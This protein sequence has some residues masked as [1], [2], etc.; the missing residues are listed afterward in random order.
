[1][2]RFSDQFP[3][4]LPAFQ[5]MF[6]DDATCARYLESIRWRDGFQCPRCAV[7]AEPIRVSRPGVLRCRGCKRDIALTA[8]T[9]MERTHT[10]LSAWF[11]AA[12]LVSSLTPGM[13]AVQLQRQLGLTRY[14]T[15]YQILHKLRSS[16][17]RP[18]RDRIG[19]RGKEHVEIDE[20]WVGGET[21]GKGSGTHD[22]ACVVTEVGDGR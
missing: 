6:P 20:T 16:M 22:M 15:A 2:E 11:W 3:E 5:R 19:G 4:S 1:M 9:V 13:S 10:P 21:R 8:G 17:V 12:Y 14:E 7:T 18:G